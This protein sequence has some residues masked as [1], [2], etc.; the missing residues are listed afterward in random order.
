VIGSAN[1]TIRRI[2]FP[3]TDM[4]E[5]EN[6]S[7]PPVPSILWHYTTY[8]AFHCI[9][10]RMYVRASEISFMNDSK[11]YW[12]ANE[13]IKSLFLEIEDDRN[14][15]ETSR[16]L[17]TFFPPEW[18]RNVA[19]VYVFSLTEDGDSLSQWRAYANS[20][21]GVAIGF[22]AK[23][24]NDIGQIGRCYY[25]SIND[26]RIHPS[27]YE[28][29]LNLSKAIEGLHSDEKLGVIGMVAKEIKSLLHLNAPFVKNLGFSE[30]RE[31][32][33]IK[34]SDGKAEDLEFY[35]KSY[36][37]SAA[38]RFNFGS[39]LPIKMVCVGP[40][41]HMYRNRLCVEQYLKSKGVHDIVVNASSISYRK[42][43]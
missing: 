40:S 42:Q 26:D 18:H 14:I 8:E 5:R 4:L 1:E 12:F 33:V 22:D 38:V 25:A 43:P 27:I 9:V 36:G 41:L 19:G 2:I 31:W 39:E 34:F 21:E 11:E 3:F 7:V 17:S 20:G 35:P 13:I 30:E 16:L 29:V 15:A 28:M 24:F 23:F 10:E 6:A 37:L 32:R